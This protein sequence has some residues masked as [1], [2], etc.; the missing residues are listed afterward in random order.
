M[1]NTTHRQWVDGSDPFYKRKQKPYALAN[2]LER[3]LLD[4][5]SQAR[6]ILVT[7]WV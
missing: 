5:G 7:L 6:E 4:L 2:G 3:V 1:Q